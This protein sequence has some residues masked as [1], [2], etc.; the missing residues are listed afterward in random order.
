MYEQIY[1]LTRMFFILKTSFTVMQ[2]LLTVKLQKNWQKFLR[3]QYLRM[4][5]IY[6]KKMF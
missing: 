6:R 1:N 5:G 3:G 2:T 4:Q